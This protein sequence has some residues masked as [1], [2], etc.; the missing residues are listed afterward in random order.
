MRCWSRTER[1]AISSVVIS[2]CRF[3]C[4]INDRWG[5]FLLRYSIIATSNSWGYVRRIKFCHS[6]HSLLCYWFL[7]IRNNRKRFCSTV[8][9]W[10]IM[11]RRGAGRWRIITT[12]KWLASRLS[13]YVCNCFRSNDRMLRLGWRGQSVRVSCRGLWL[14]PGVKLQR[15]TEIKCDITPAGM[16]DSI[17]IACSWHRMTLVVHSS[18]T[19]MTK[20]IW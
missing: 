6:T 7:L 17:T 3:W 8:C 10:L 14:L 1:A 16:T 5:D 18:I 15:E 4:S 20:L 11:L 19:Q 13:R 2:Y 12:W 9:L